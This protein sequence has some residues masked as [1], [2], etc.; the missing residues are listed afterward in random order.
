MRDMDLLGTDVAIKNMAAI[1][2]WYHDAHSVR[3]LGDMFSARM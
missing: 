3:I 2:A 1:R